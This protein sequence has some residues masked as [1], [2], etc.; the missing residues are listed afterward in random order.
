V[1]VEG[2]LRGGPVEQVRRVDLRAE[3]RA[4]SQLGPAQQLPGGVVE[5]GRLD[6]AAAATARQPDVTHPGDGHRSRRRGE[7][8]DD[9][10]HR[11]APRGHDGDTDSTGQPAGTR[12][13]HQRRPAAR[14]RRVPGIGH[15]DRAGCFWISRHRSSPASALR[16]GRAEVL[17]KRQVAAPLMARRAADGA[18]RGA[19]RRLQPGAGIG[20]QLAGLRLSREPQSAAPG[21]PG[22]ETLVLGFAL[23]TPAAPR[24]GHHRAM[25][26]QRGRKVAP[27]SHTSTVEQHFPGW[28]PSGR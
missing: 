11:G 18:L 16:V 21:Q 8:G 3:N 25:R 1:A 22:H 26:R 17:G 28:G 19:H 15:R 2:C 20:V 4:D 27:C 9:P 6:H 24:P 13:E 7:P 10:G 14:D 5:T 23:T 12:R